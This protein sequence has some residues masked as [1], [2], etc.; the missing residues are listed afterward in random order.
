MSSSVLLVLCRSA[1]QLLLIKPVFGASCV[2]MERYSTG[3]ESE[4]LRWSYDGSCSAQQ[5][6]DTRH[7][8]I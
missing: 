7:S 8:A 5:D 6:L 4:G 3:V 1:V 2:A